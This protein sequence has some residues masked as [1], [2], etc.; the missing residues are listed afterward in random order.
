[1]YS[2]D[3]VRPLRGA[4][5]TRVLVSETCRNC[6]WEVR[7]VAAAIA[8]SPRR[9]LPRLGS[10]RRVGESRLMSFRAKS[11]HTLPACPKRVHRQDACAT[12]SGDV[13]TS[14]DMTAT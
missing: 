3:V 11:K 2:W 12:I 14:L 7:D 8:S 9:P 6:R 4:Y 5:A 1:M 10:K 13:S